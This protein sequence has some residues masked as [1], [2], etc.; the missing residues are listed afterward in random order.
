MRGT[1][2]IYGMSLTI[3]IL[4]CLSFSNVCAVCTLGNIWARPP[5]FSASLCGF[6]FHD[7]EMALLFFTAC[8][9]I[10]I[11]FCSSSDPSFLQMFLDEFVSISYGGHNFVRMGHGG[12]CDVLLAELG[13]V[14]ASLTV[15]CI[16]VA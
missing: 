9:V 13:V 6:G 2:G 5:C 7:V 12:F 8:Y 10:F 16:D 1:L 11:N 15:G 3:F 14:G 4:V